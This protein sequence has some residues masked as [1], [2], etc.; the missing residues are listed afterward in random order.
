MRAEPSYLGA[1]VSFPFPSSPRFKDLIEKINDN[2]YKV[3]LPGEYNV[4]LLSMF[5]IYLHLKQAKIRGRILL[6][7]G[8]MMGTK[9]GLI[10][11]IFC[12]FQIGQL[13]D[14][15]SRRSRKQCND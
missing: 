1:Y 15:E 11:K 12:K 2:A 4:L 5:L 3:D 13:Q 6:R 14:L 8:G 10:L 7:R 9:V